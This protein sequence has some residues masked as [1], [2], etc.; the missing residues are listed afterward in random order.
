VIQKTNPKRKKT[1]EE[2]REEIKQLVGDEYTVLSDYEG[3]KKNVT[4]RHNTCGNIYEVRP[5]N[6]ISKGYRCKKCRKRQKHT[7][8]PMLSQ[9]E[10]EKRIDKKYN[11]E[12]SVI[13]TY[14]GM[15]NNVL[16]RHNNCGSEF[17]VNA[18]TLAYSPSFKCKFCSKTYLNNYEEELIYEIENIIKNELKRDGRF[19]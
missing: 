9:E 5:D 7:T 12:F 8:K 18:R 19:E 1:P 4:M 17:I 15:E 3:C 13:S 16:V 14:E 2:F 6:F 10:F 11:G